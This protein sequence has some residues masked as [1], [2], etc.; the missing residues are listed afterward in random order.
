MMLTGKWMADGTWKM[1]P[2]FSGA[3]GS[4]Q[5]NLAAQAEQMNR[6]QMVLGL[7]LPLL[8]KPRHFAHLR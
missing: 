7:V 8:G 5:N 1:S 4:W 6:V 2:N 3:G